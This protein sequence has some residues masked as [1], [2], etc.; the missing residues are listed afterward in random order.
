MGIED[1]ITRIN[2]NLCF[3]YDVIIT[4]EK[5]IDKL[6]ELNIGNQV[7]QINDKLN[8]LYLQVME[9]KSEVNRPDIPVVKETLKTED[10]KKLDGCA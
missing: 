5:K 1:D 9:K 2:K 4:L 8:E 3:I 7:K 10:G 6:L